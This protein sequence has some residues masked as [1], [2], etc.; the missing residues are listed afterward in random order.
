MDGFVAV[1]RGL[2]VTLTNLVMRRR[3]TLQYPYVRPRVSARYRG[4]FYLPF[5][6]AGNRLRCV[7]CTLCAQACPTKVITMKKL[8]AGKHAGV[9]EFRMD[10]GRCMYCNLCIEACPFDAIHMGP[11][12]ELASYDQNA[13][14]F[15]IADLASGGADAVARNCATIEAALL[16]ER[17]AAQARAHSSETGDEA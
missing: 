17:E 10:L 13:S 16:A 3:E 6:E 15:E 4:L 5:D 14:V 2:G 8:G 7:G 12:F 1:F 9:S 11:E